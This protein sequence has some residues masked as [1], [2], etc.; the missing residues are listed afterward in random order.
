MAC[1]TIEGRTIQ[2]VSTGH[3]QSV[4]IIWLDQVIEKQP[5]LYGNEFA[6]LEK[7]F[8][9]VKPFSNV[10]ECVQFITGMRDKKIYLISSG[11]LG[12]IVAPQLQSM[13]QVEGIY[14]F[15]ENKS[16]HEEW[17]KNYS[18]VKGLFTGMKAICDALEKSIRKRDNHI[19]AMGYSTRSDD[20]MNKSLDQ[21]DQLFVCGQIFKEILLSIQWKRNN[22]KEVLNA[23]AKRL[24]DSGDAL[25]S[26][27]SYDASKAIKLYLRSP[28]LFSLINYTLNHLDIESMMRIGFFIQDLHEDINQ[29]FTKQSAQQWDSSSY[30]V[31]RSQGLFMDD[32]SRLKRTQNGLIS[33]T[34]FL[35]ANKE[36]K[37]SLEI[38]RETTKDPEL[39]GI[40][41]AMKM[42]SSV[43]STPF[44][45]VRDIKRKQQ[46]GDLLLSM[47]SVFR[48]E[49][50]QNLEGNNRLWEV[51]LTLLD[52]KEPQLHM[53]TEHIRE[54][55]YPYLK[56]WHR[57]GNSLM[58]LQNLN[59]AL[60]V[61][62]L[63]LTEENNDENAEIYRKL[64]I[65]KEQQEEYDMAVSLYHKSLEI[66]QKILPAMHSN[67]VTCYILLGQ[68]YSKTGIHQQATTFLQKALEI[69]EKFLPPNHPDLVSSY[70]RLGY[71]YYQW[72]DYIKA[73]DFQQKAYEI[74]R[75]ILPAD[76]L[77]LAKTAYNIGD[78]L[79]KRSQFS[80]AIP[81]LETAIKIGQ[82][83][84]SADDPILLQWQA[85]LDNVKK[86]NSNGH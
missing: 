71:A 4:M 74:Y 17:A 83:S 26:G 55:T 66:N 39:I 37:V 43:S 30:V 9:R 72:G 7:L 40:L 48:I 3:L 64:G 81:W 58:K 38:A 76:H 11:T 78:A 24:V 18:K 75:R 69:Q 46:A 29:T 14:I 12:N 82:S 35:L 44:V 86:F 34:N 33:F 61:F 8:E 68:V 21:F 52:N 80:K 85:D 73:V 10:D 27:K 16:K 31:Y 47:N 45:D 2:Q 23:D 22:Q 65:I 50:V 60:Q 1:E 51:Q 25:P 28:G 62:Q 53:L 13:N 63:M 56:G 5:Q 15:C 84:L 77:D 57:L 59:K 42:N 41:F 67:L 36:R 20:M 19:I 6:E 79:N 54:E 32:F 49:T 70:R